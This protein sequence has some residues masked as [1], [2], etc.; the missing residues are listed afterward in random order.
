LLQGQVYL[1]E[2]ERTPNA[3]AI[4]EFNRI[5][6]EDPR[7]EQVLLP[8]RDGLTVIRRVD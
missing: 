4:A 6:A 7:V 5:V 3:Q 2:E 8:L 1:P